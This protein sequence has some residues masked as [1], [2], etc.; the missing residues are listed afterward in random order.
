MLLISYIA[1]I[2]FTNANIEMLLIVNSQGNTGIVL[3][4]KHTDTQMNEENRERFQ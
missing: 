4:K 1:H 2:F 3:L